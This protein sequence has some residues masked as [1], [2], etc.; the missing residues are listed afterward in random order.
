MIIPK[1]LVL[2]DSFINNNVG[3][4]LSFDGVKLNKNNNKNRFNSIIYRGGLV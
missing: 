3:V 1:N 2:L 4:M